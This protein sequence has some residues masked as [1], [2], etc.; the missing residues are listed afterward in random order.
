[1]FKNQG[2]RAKTA[3]ELGLS[4]RALYYKLERYDIAIKNKG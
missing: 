3:K 1:M 2:N 4:L